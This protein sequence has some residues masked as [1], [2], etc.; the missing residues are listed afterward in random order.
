V[1]GADGGEALLDVADHHVADHLARAKATRT[2]APFQQV[3]SS[4]SEHHRKFDRIVA[5]WPSCSRGL[6]ASGMAFE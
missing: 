4:A 2:T 1:W 3:N 6:R 5:T